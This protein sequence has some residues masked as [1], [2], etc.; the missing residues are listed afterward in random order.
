MLLEGRATLHLL[1]G[2]AAAAAVYFVAQ[3]VSQRR[4]FKN[5]PGPPHSSIWGHLKLMGEYT[6][7]VPSKTYIQTL[8]TQIHQDYNLGDLF[9]L[10]MWPFGPSFLIMSG[11]DAA[12]IP[13]TVHNFPQHPILPDFF[14]DTVGTSFI[15]ATNGALWKDLFQQITP[16]LTPSAIKGHQ[17]LILHAAK[18]VHARLQDLAEKGETAIMNVELG[19][20]PFTVITSVF[21]GEGLSMQAYKDTLRLTE[22]VVTRNIPGALANPITKWKWTREKNAYLSRLDNEIEARV[23]ARFKELQEHKENPSALGAPTLLDRMLKSRLHSG[24]TLDKN[25][26]KL[27]MDNAKGFIVAGYGTTTDTSTYIYILLSTHPEILQKMR[28]EHDEVLGKD[29]DRTLEV[30]QQNPAVTSQLEYTTAVIHETLRL[31]P[32]GMVVREA[33]PGVTSIEYNKVKYPLLKN[34]MIGICAHIMHHDPEIYQDPKRFWP[35]RFLDPD[36]PI[37]RN[38][39]R[40]FE[41]GV[42][43]CMGQPLAMDEMRLLAVFLARS[44]DFEMVG[45]EPAKK[46]SLSSSDLDTKLGDFAF[47]ISGFSAG[48]P[49]PVKMRI[50]KSSWSR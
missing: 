36:R 34:H 32:I 40:P 4:F 5:L 38:A 1:A 28:E 29:L 39:F 12:A 23:L 22:L 10:D 24:P 37:P 14:A 16:G 11:P 3:L 48:P 43:S 31:Y 46:P 20:L 2:L 18:Q 9:Y 30:L 27:I 41:R 42:R 19:I 45:Y 25:H 49:V 44:F 47:Q 35:E 26:L 21:F 17:N 6:K 33:P 15:E 7:K 13:T 50:K 8:L